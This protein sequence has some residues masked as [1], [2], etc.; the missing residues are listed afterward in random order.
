MLENRATGE[1]G[2]AGFHRVQPEVGAGKHR[3]GLA[4]GSFEGFLKNS[5]LEEQPGDVPNIMNLLASHEA[6]IRFLGED[7]KKCSEQYKDASTGDFLLNIQQLHE[8]MACIL[9][10]H[11]E[12]QLTATKKI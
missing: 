5:R 7:A 10:A 11:I 1:R 2:P 8:K 9:R 6:A 4:T 3:G 12:P